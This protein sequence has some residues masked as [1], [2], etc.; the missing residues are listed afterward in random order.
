MQRSAKR[1]VSPLINVLYDQKDN[2]CF[3]AIL[4]LMCA[5][6]CTF[7]A[8]DNIYE[9]SI[10]CYLG[11]ELLREDTYTYSWFWTPQYLNTANTRDYISKGGI[12]EKL[13]TELYEKRGIKIEDEWYKDEACTFMI[14][15]DY[16]VTENTNFYCKMKA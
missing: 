13:Q 14:C 11:D 15:G 4:L 1:K 3:L 10:K 12:F 7:C 2:L 5:I 9:Y 6:L 8:C 16:E